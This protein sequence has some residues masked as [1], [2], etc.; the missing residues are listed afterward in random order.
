[1]YMDKVSRW[2][3]AHKNLQNARRSVT[4]K[5]QHEERMLEG[6]RLAYATRVPV[7]GLRT[8]FAAPVGRHHPTMGYAGASFSPAPIA[9]F[10]STYPHQ[11]ARIGAAETSHYGALPFAPVYINH[12]QKGHSGRQS[13]GSVQQEPLHVI[14]KES[15]SFSAHHVPRFMKQELGVD[16]DFN[17][18]KEEQE[19]NDPRRPQGFASFEQETVPVMKRESNHLF[20]SEVPRFIKNEPGVGSDF[21][22][23]KEEHD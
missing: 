14:H 21:E 4:N 5:V 16:S 22:R 2:A 20:G 19:Q 9:R 10:Q 13:I 3:W 7:G 6:A 15:T 1:M 8:S 23:I 11:H 17:R 18:G 12:E